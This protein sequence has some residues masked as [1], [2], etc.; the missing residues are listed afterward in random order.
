MAAEYRW[1]PQLAASQLRPHLQ[2][3]NHSEF[4]VSPCADL[5]ATELDSIIS[6]IDISANWNLHTQEGGE[7]E[8]AQTIL[9]GNYVADKIFFPQFLVIV[10]IL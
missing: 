5:L 3:L 2:N 9:P 8:W 6:L 4:T 1:G 10:K 7:T